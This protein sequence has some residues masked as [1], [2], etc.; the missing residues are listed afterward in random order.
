MGY[1]ACS[2]YPKDFDPQTQGFG[3]Y[4]R[5]FDP[6]LGG[7]KDA[8]RVLRMLKKGPFWPRNIGSV[9]MKTTYRCGVLGTSSLSANDIWLVPHQH[10]HGLVGLVGPETSQGLMISRRSTSAL[11]ATE[12]LEFL[13]SEEIHTP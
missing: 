4:Y 6:Y 12:R 7:S 13:G 5:G 1:I 11:K 3:G 10:L 8:Y 2:H 9:W